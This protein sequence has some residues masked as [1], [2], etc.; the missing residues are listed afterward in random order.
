MVMALL[1]DDGEIVLDIMMWFIYFCG[2]VL[3]GAVPSLLLLPVLL[4][5]TGLGSEDVRWYHSVPIM[6]IVGVMINQIIGVI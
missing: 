1:K 5:I 3:I 2:M 6:F 4:G